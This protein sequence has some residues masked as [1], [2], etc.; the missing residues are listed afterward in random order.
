MEAATESPAAVSLVVP[1]P[2]LRRAVSDYGAVDRA[3]AT[4]AKIGG[5]CVFHVAD[6]GA[7]VM[8]L[9]LI[10]VQRPI[11]TMHGLR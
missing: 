9:W 10:P 7:L 8:C 11:A 3:I 1:K 4:G 6:A 5:L 2:I